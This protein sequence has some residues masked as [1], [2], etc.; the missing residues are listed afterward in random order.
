MPIEEI[1]VGDLVLAKNDQ[2]GELAYKRVVELFPHDKEELYLLYVDGAIIETTEEHPFWNEELKQWIPVH[3]LKIGDELTT[4]DGKQIVIHDIIIKKGI[5]KVFN[6]EVEDFHTYFVGKNDI[7]THNRCNKQK[8]IF[9]NY[10]GYKA[11]GEVHHGLPEKYSD[12]FMKKGINVNDPQY[13]YDIPKDMHRLKSGN[14]LHTK[15]SPLGEDWNKIWGEWIKNHPNATKKDIE[16]QLNKMAT[17]GGIEKNR[18]KARK[19]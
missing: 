7:W 11:T 2:T 19:K 4:K 3:D 1:E 9:E 6:F 18:A 8:E 14:G 15:N 10:T 5:T 12:W 13:Y 16:K 17:Q